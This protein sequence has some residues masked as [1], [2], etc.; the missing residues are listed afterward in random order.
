MI[1]PFFDDFSFL[2]A[3]L[4]CYPTVLLSGRFHPMITF[5]SG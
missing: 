1:N 3:V 5:Q 2:V 4:V